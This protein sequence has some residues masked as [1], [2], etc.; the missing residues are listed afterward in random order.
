MNPQKIEIV[1]A[2][3]ELKS[4][5]LNLMLY[6]IH[7][8]TEF[9][10]FRCP[11]N[12]LYRTDC[13][14]QYWNPPKGWAFVIKVEGEL[15]GFVLVEGHGTQPETQFSIGEFFIMRKFRGKGVGQRV[16]HSIFDRFHGRWEAD[17]VI[18]NKPALAFWRKVTDRYTAGRCVE[19][20]EPVRRG[21]FT[22]IVRTFDNVPGP[23]TMD[24]IATESG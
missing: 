12:G 7:D 10:G 24:R 23:R 14:E 8:F 4:V 18:E 13:F 19:L 2:K 15:A 11:D 6:Y 16:A 20:P 9:L 5:V 17:V 1:E 21:Q 3:H 22:E